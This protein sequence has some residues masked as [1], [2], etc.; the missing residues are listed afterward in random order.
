MFMAKNKTDDTKENNKKPLW[1]KVFLGFVFIDAIVGIVFLICYL[2]G[3]LPF[4]N[5]PNTSL[6]STST[7][8]D[9]TQGLKL[10]NK[11][12]ELVQTQMEYD[13]YDNQELKDVIAVTYVNNTPTSFN[14][15]ISA[16]T[17]S[18]LFN[19]KIENVQYKEG[20][21]TLVSYL[22]CNNEIEGDTDLYSE[23]LFSD[24]ESTQN[25]KSVISV[26]NSG[27]KH[28]TGY[29]LVGTEYVIDQL[30][31]YDSNIH[32]QTIKQ[33]DALY[34]YYRYLNI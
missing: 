17:D 14:L 13:G 11:F 10:D 6:S 7:P 4:N 23:E 24:V 30:E 8:I 21:D 29:A 32:S 1:K 22:L 15:S 27:I 26:S 2:K 18:R 5:K 31:E 3:C 16:A 19:L 28:R 20:N 9:Y 12:R 34:N 25:S 33:D